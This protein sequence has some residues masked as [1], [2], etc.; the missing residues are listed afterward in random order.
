MA[1]NLPGYYVVLDGIVGCGKSKQNELLKKYLPL[2]FPTLSL[3][4]TYEPGGNPE[5]DKIRQRLKQEKMDPELEMELFARSRA[6]TLPQVVAPVL[7]RGGVVLSDRSVTTSLA[8][9]A[10]GRELG[11]NKVWEANKRAVNGIFPD[12]VIWMNVNRDICLQRSGSEN[13]DKFDKENLAFWDRTISGFEEMLMFM[14]EISPKTETITINDI[15]GRLG[16]EDMRTQ[17]KR[18]LYPRLNIFLG[19]EGQVIRKRQR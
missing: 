9:Q 16:I 15:E 18:E 6:I 19:K 1:N 10:F 11:M 17:I 3:T 14:K 8:Y 7:A 4:F 2:D 13:S 5:A 12:L